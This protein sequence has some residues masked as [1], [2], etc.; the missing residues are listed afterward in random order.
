MPTP[1]DVIQFALLALTSIFFTVN[2]MASIPSFLAMG[3][4]GNPEHNRTM[5]RRASWTCFLV[6]IAFAFAGSVIFK[7]FGI[8][9]PAFKIA[10]GVLLFQI[11]L[12]MLRSRR[13]ETQEVEAERTEGQGKE[14]F[15]ITPLGVPM[16]S[17]PGAISVVMVLNAQSKAWWQEVPI[18]LAIALTAASCYF[19]LTAGMPLQ[20]RLGETGIRILTRLMG[21]VLAA[22]AVQFVLDARSEE[23]RVGKECRSRWS[24]YH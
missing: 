11:A 5:A 8:T 6:L 22:M 17:G 24:P 15:G 9:L 7:L 10:G 20:K 23:R 18:V 21:L 13:S 3:A 19:I 1:S 14:D 2:P 12:E 16:L 4:N